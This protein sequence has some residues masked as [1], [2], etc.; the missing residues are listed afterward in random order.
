[1][2][3]R[4]ED[5]ELDPTIVTIEDCVDASPETVRAWLDTLNTLEPIDPGLSTTAIIREMQ[6]HGER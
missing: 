5:F 3:R 1:M 2:A 4:T 6:E